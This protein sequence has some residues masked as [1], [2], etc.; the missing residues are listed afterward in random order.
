MPKDK[1]WQVAAVNS[2][3][4]RQLADEAGISFLLARLLINRGIKDS[5]SAK[6]FFS[7]LN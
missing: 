6:T 5:L 1:I 2:G 3:L 4:E 7:P